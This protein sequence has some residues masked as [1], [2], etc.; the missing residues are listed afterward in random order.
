MS[1]MTATRM[2][3]P[4]RLADLSGAR[5]RVGGGGV[6]P[7]GLDEGAGRA[8]SGRAVR[9]AGVFTGALPAPRASTTSRS[10]TARAR[11]DRRRRV[12]VFG[13]Y[14]W[15]GRGSRASRRP[16]RSAPGCCW[17]C[18][19][20]AL[21]WLVSVPFEVL[22]ALVAAP[23]RPVAREL[24]RGDLRRLARCSASS[25]SSSASPCS[26]SMGL[27]RLAAAASGGSR[28][29]ASS[30]ASSALHLHRAVPRRRDTHPLRDPKLQRGRGARSPTKEGVHGVPIR[31]QDVDTKDRERLHGRSRADSRKVFIWSSLL[32]GRFTER[33]VEVVVAHE[34]GHQARNHLLKGIAWYALVHAS[35]SP[36]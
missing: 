33:Q 8:A 28:P 21:V 2:G 34:Y 7:L 25:S 5:S 17:R 23:L 1:E 6:P 31:V 16:A 4:L 32:D 24:R 27:A 15:R 13:L 18:S 26:S 12:V 10:S 22:G 3:S 19:A 20:S 29:S 9:R 30:S 36:T 11:P 35:R 14:A